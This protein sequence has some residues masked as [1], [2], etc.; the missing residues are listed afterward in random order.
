M[1]M[2]AILL[3][4]MEVKLLYLRIFSGECATWRNKDAKRVAVVRG[5]FLALRLVHM[6]RKVAPDCQTPPQHSEVQ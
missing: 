2:A 5:A 6:V 3:S 4:L 1:G